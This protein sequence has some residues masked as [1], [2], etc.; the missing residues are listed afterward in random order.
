MNYTKYKLRKC[1]SLHECVICGNKIKYDQLY[2]DGKYGNRA[3]KICAE[4]N[5]KNEN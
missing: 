4:R 5:N 1:K 3:H 2:Y